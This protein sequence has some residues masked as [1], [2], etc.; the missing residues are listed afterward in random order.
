MERGNRQAEFQ[1]RD[2]D[3]SVAARASRRT[4]YSRNQAVDRAIDGKSRRKIEVV[5]Q[6]HRCSDPSYDALASSSIPPSPCQL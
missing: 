2:T 1:G 4:L 6:L 3:G 5:L